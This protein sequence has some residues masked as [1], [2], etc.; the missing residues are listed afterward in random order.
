MAGVRLCGEVPGEELSSEEVGLFESCEKPP[1]S[2]KDMMSSDFSLTSSLWPLCGEQTTGDS[3]RDRRLSHKGAGVQTNSAASGSK[4]DG[5]RP[6]RDMYWG[7]GEDSLKGK[8]GGW[9]KTHCLHLTDKE[10]EA[11]KVEPRI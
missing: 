8:A 3:E 11:Q 4:E 2:T 7:R 10:T 9:E 1:E 6:L 5:D